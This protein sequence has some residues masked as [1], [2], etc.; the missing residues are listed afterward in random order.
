[1]SFKNDIDS[2]VLKCTKS[3]EKIIR[4]SEMDLF[5]SIVLETPVDKGVLRG[6]WYAQLGAPS[7]ATTDNA[8]PSG[9]LAITKLRKLLIRQTLGMSCIFRITY[10][11]L[12]P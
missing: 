8:D 1:M 9:Q 4:Q 6:N 7:M 11:T 2:F 3:M 12:T 10:L 5:S